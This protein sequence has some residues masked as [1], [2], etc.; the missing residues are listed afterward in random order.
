MDSSI[1]DVVAHCGDVAAHLEMWWV[2]LG[3]VV[4]Y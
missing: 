4:A 1:G 2:H 3:D